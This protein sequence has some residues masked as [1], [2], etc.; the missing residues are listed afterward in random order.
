MGKTIFSIFLT[1][2]IIVYHKKQKIGDLKVLIIEIKN[3]TF[4]FIVIFS[5]YLYI[6]Q[7]PDVDAFLIGGM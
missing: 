1:F 4:V 2:N 7:L 6:P 5:K 3:Q